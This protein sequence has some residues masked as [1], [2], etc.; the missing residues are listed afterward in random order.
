MCCATYNTLTST[1][2]T[3]RFCSGR[4]FVSRPTDTPANTAWAPRIVQPALLRRDIPIPGVSGS[5]TRLSYGE[6]TLANADGGLDVLTDYDFSGRSIIVRSGPETGA[7]PD[8]FTL[9]LGAVVESVRIGLREVT[10]K[11][12]SPRV[13]WEQPVATAVYGGT[14]SDG[15]GIDGESGQEGVTKPVCLINRL[16]CAPAWQPAVNM[17]YGGSMGWTADTDSVKTMGGAT[18]YD[19]RTPR[20]SLQMT[21]EALTPEQA[22]AWP[23]E[24]QRIL[25]IDGELFFVYD[26]M[27]TDLLMKQ[28]SFLATLRQRVNRNRLTL[29]FCWRRGRDSNPRYVAVHLISSHV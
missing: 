17:S 2:E 8:D 13:N 6:L 24:L 23:W 14:N 19:R 4:G 10:V 21:V 15:A 20:R 16:I 5:V 7:Y 26:P 3:L 11:I 27:D 12:K 25:G 9:Q 1:E 29:C 18:W 22:M 28:R